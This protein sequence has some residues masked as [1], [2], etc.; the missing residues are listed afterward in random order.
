MK[1][2]SQYP[3][4]FAYGATDGLY[5]AP[6]RAQS[7]NPS[8]W[9]RPY[10]I[11]DDRAMPIGTPVIVNGV[12]IGLSG[13]RY[14]GAHL[15]I[16][17]FVGGGATNPNGGGFSFTNAVVTEINEDDVN[18][19][20]VR[21]QADGASW[22]YLHLSNNNLVT[23]NQQL[24]GETD[25][26]SLETDDTTN[27]LYAAIFH[28]APED[29]VAYSSWR[30]KPVVEVINSLY[31]SGEWKGLDGNLKVNDGDVVNLYRFFL[32][33]DP[34]AG[35]GSERIG[36]LFKD[37]LYDIANSDEAKAVRAARAA[38]D[39][40]IATLQ[41][42]EG[43]DRATIATQLDQIAKLEAQVNNTQ[44]DPTSAAKLDHIYQTT[45]DTKNMVQK[46]IDLL[47]SKFSFSKKK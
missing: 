37:N 22:V 5:Y 2:A 33:R 6:T 31:N 34:E 7:S 45:T 15:H 17:R 8:L 10:H 42:K 35:A 1:D 26:P 44:L 36:K 43:T 20:Y 3:V 16:G 41:S 27:L 47:L 38:K 21:V 9:I 40:L 13:T 14:G 4:S 18:G 46:I 11:G 39:Q 19:K 30:D 25:M 12:T 32:D 24:K 28:R 23:V 29:A